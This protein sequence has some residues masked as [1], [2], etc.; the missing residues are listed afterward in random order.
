M[1]VERVFYELVACQDEGLLWWR[2]LH[3]SQKTKICNHQRFFWEQN[4]PSADFSV[5]DGFSSLIDD[6]FSGCR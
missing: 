4:T 5:D 6:S 1:G 2:M 3:I